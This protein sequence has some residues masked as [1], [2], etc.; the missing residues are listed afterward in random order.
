MAAAVSTPAMAA[1]SQRFRP[2]PA[3]DLEQS[4]GSRLRCKGLKRKHQCTAILPFQGLR[5]A[6]LAS[7]IAGP[8]ATTVPGDCGAD[9]FKIEA[10][11]ERAPKPQ[12]RPDPFGAPTSA[13]PQ[14]GLRR[15]PD[16]VLG[17]LRCAGAES[18]SGRRVRSV[19]TA[20]DIP[21]LLSRVT[22]GIT[23]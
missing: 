8:V 9:V 23:L 21:G 18:G 15:A 3:I 5:A 7:L 1:A 17:N 6:D 13:R 20:V 16:A 4:L 14:A 10:P 19:E 22:P 12:V 2:T 11:G